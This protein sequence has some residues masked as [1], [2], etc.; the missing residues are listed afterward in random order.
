MFMFFQIFEFIQNFKTLCVSLNIHFLE[1]IIF[2]GD[3]KNVNHSF[4]NVHFVQILKCSFFRNSKNV[5]FLVKHSFE[6]KH[7]VEISSQIK[8][9]TCFQNLFGI[10]EKC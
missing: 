8:N 6:K 7:F 10:F 4:E 5:H 9:M 2:W 3:L 1:N